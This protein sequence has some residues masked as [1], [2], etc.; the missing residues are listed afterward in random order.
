M[1]APNERVMDMVRREIEKNPSIPSQELF[2]KA[3]KMDSSMKRLTIRQFHATY[4][5]QV[6]RL[7]K[8]ARRRGRPRKA[9]AAAPVK[10]GRRRRGA[11]KAAPAKRAR[12]PGRPPGRPAGRPPG[13]PRGRPPGRPR[14]AATAA[15]SAARNEGV[16]D[17]DAVRTILLQFASE[18]A[19][20]EGKADIVQVMGT[21]ERYV[22]RLVQATSS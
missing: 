2:E 17:R 4:P 16:S 1:A 12:R 14:A 3:K 19:G 13:R 18:V 7:S 6:K 21:M 11:A 20:A 5:L 22:D 8:G 9:A 10:R 15:A